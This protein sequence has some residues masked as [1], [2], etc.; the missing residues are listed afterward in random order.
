M[1]RRRTRTDTRR[2]PEATRDRLRKA[3]T[4]LFLSRGY[5]ATSIGAIEKA[6]GLAPR[7]GGFYRHYP[8]KQALLSDLAR[9]IIENPSEMGF[10]EL[11]PLGDTRAELFLIARGYRK[12]AARQAPLAALIAEVRELPEV[13]E[14]VG[15]TEE[16][17]R[18]HFGAWIAT[19]PAA[20]SLGTADRLALVLMI[21]GGWI[22]FLGK[23]EA[24]W[25]AAELHDEAMLER[26]AMYWA[27]VLDAPSPPF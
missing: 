12:A 24:P 13:L 11:L 20:A 5:R 22:L 10:A 2:T 8:S 27:R 21:L 17:L 14:L 16:E 3:A 15:R 9:D 26:W 19:K 25:L 23:R 6:A 1:D 7:T 4:G 18:G